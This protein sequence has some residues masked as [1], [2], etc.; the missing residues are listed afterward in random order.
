MSADNW[1]VCPR[2]KAEDAAARQRHEHL[3]GEKYGQISQ[4]QY[5]K[6]CQD[7]KDWPKVPD[8]MRED[9]ELGMDEDGTFYVSYR[10]ECQA[11]GFAHYFK[12][13]YL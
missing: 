1:M 11:C 4:M 12:Q 2:C 8:E 5:A 10:C 9:W 7:L 13:G 6:L 3:I